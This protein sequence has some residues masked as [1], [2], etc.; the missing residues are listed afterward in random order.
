MNHFAS[1]CANTGAIGRS[2]VSLQTSAG[3]GFTE[4]IMSRSD[5]DKT[6]TSP[7]RLRDVR[8]TALRE[9]F[10]DPDV[11]DQWAEKKWEEAI[12]RKTA[13]MMDIV[14]KGGAHLVV[15]KRTLINTKTDPQTEVGQEEILTEEAVFIAEEEGGHVV[16]VH[17]LTEFKVHPMNRNSG[18]KGLFTTSLRQPGSR[19]A[20]MNHGMTMKTEKWLIHREIVWKSNNSGRSGD[21]TRPGPTWRSLQRRRSP[22]RW[23]WVDRWTETGRV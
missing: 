4:T 16:T 11:P 17:I 7:W 15:M 12:L 19:K 14:K 18:K 20:R 3:K 9:I 10:P 21:S 2:S 5:S 6:V 22:S 13:M 8:S 23:T 1:S